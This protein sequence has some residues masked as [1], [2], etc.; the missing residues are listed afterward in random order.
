MT[1]S[2]VPMHVVAADHP[3]L[4]GHFPG[5]PIVPGAWLLA[6]VIDDAAAWL[7]QQPAAAAAGVTHVQRVQGVRSVKFLQP[8]R[9]GQP[10]TI[11]FA[12]GTGTLRFT[13]SRADGARCASGVLELI[14]AA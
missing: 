2:S 10:F 1:D 3:M 13:L 11:A 8:V 7:A 6:Q 5:D 14:D 4:P 12:P 9:P